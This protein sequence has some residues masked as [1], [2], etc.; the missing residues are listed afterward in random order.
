[1][2]E[3]VRVEVVDGDRTR[4]LR[5]AVLRPSWPA[6]SP[7]GGDGEP[8]AVHLAAL[9]A[10][11]DVVCACVLY[12]R[13]YP[14]RPEERNAWQLRGMATAE[15]VRNQGVGAQVIAKAVTE[16]R[17]R[18]GRLLWCE[19][20]ELAIAFYARNGFHGEGEMYIG[21]ETGIPHQL[22]CRELAA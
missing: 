12:P 7:L 13:T 8:G 18:G 6:G 22:M 10:A 14:R 17:S 15:A 1:V 21:A 4:E 16:V 20:R 19:A 9:D 11:A 5:R 3:I 2:G